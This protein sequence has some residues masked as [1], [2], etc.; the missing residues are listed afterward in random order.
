M[1]NLAS[2]LDYYTENDIHL[3]NLLN[4][5]DVCPFFVI[6]LIII[7]V[8]SYKNVGVVMVFFFWTK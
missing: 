5:E 7:F 1:A 8:F 6:K 4:C 2:T 3:N